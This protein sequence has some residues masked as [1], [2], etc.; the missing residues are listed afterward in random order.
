MVSTGPVVVFTLTRILE[1]NPP[2]IPR[3]LHGGDIIT[4][5][6]FQPQTTLYTI[7]RCLVLE[8]VK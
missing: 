4:D 7:E 8:N 2:Q 3:D 1:G 5:D 6:K